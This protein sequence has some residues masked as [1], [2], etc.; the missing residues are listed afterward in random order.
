MVSTSLFFFLLLQGSE[1]RK[2]P[3]KI[4]FPL[5]HFFLPSLGHQNEEPIVSLEHSLCGE[6]ER[7]R[8][9]GRA[10]Q[11]ARDRERERGFERK[12]SMQEG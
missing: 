7:E 5:N 3:R 11:R 6:R 2:V 1:K 9:R 4:G 8:E 10:T 12:R